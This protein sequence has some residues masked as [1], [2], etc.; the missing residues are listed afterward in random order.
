[1]E[2]FIVAI[3]CTALVY[4]I[5][6]DSKNIDVVCRRTKR[7]GPNWRCGEI[8]RGARRAVSGMRRVIHGRAKDSSNIYMPTK[9][10][11]F[12]LFYSLFSFKQL[13]DLELHISFS[14]DT[15]FS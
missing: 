1:M 15:I 6:K 13:C 2:S 12:H 11:E 8:S 3:C 9:H 4:L 7:N 14:F 5:L 10:V